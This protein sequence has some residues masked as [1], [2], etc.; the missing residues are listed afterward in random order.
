VRTVGLAEQTLYAE[1]LDRCSAAAFDSEFPPN[2]SFVKVEIKS[3]KYWYFQ[4]GSRDASGRQPRKYVGPNT[5]EIRSKVENHG[6]AK[7][8]FRE[9][10]HLISILRRS[11]FMG[12]VAPA[13]Q[14][15]SALAAAGVFRMRACLVGTT[16]YQLYG[17]LLG[18]RLPVSAL[19][20]GDLDIAQF[21][22]I[23]V[24]IAQDEETPPFIEILQKA[25]PTFRHVPHS[26]KAAASTAYINSIGYRVEVLTESRGVNSEAPVRLPAIGTHAHPLRFLDFLIY[27]EIPAVVLHSAGVLV[28]VP[29][30]ARYAIHKLAIAQRRRSG[31]AKVD[32]D[33]QQAQALIEALILKNPEELRDVWH[34]AVARGSTWKKLLTRGLGMISRRVRDRAL[35]VFGETRSIIPSVDLRFEDPVPEYDP[36]SERIH[37][38]G[39]EGVERVACAISR[40][41]LNDLSFHHLG[42]ASRVV[43]DSNRSDIEKLA[44][45]IYLHRPVS[46]DGSVL[47]TTAETRPLWES[48]LK[49]Q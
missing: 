19:Q 42:S 43:F 15:I 21:T 31:I 10:R 45:D 30:P 49:G 37:F 25:D 39:R 33:L 38:E 24:A 17:P 6:H 47:I 20:T 1:L 22:S 44:R 11:G 5:P 2:G 4:Q 32:K 36:D 7:G 3:R 8:D 9:R 14:I 23:S 18:V 48:R 46:A 34:E 35:F 16:A 13:G 12:P 29:A 27:D 40:E 41:A 28:N 26:R